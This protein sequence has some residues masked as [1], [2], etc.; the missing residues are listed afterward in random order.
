[1]RE[2]FHRHALIA[3]TCEEIFGGVKDRFNVSEKDVRSDANRPRAGK[4]YRGGKDVTVEQFQDVFG[5][6]GAEFGKW[7]GQGKGA[8]ERQFFLNNTYDALMDL[9][10]IQRKE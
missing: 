4:D 1:M 3:V 9:A 6:R 5:F 8:Q 7:V 10:E 2:V